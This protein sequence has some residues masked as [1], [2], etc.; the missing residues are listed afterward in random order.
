[1][2]SSCNN[3]AFW[4]LCKRVSTPFLS[5]KRKG[6]CQSMEKKFYGINVDDEQRFLRMK[7]SEE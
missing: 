4:A 6:I 7:Y 1:M 2:V 3:K 5:T